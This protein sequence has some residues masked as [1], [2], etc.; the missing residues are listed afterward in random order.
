ME[1]EIFNQDR[2]NCEAY[3]RINVPVLARIED[4]NLPSGE[5]VPAMY[6]VR[7]LPIN[8]RFEE[9]LAYNND[10]DYYDNDYDGDYEVYDDAMETLGLYDTIERAMEVMSN[11][12]HIR[13][14]KPNTTYYMPKE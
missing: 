11:I 10:V 4:I 12:I 2:D 8:A 6:A 5:V 7:G 9:Q 3:S 14:Q 1:F 13:N